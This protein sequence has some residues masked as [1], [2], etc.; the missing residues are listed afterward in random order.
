MIA[1]D[2]ITYEFVKGRPHAPQG[3]DW[4][5][6]VV[7]AWD[8]LKTDGRRGFRRRRG[9]Y[10]R[11][12]ADAVRH[13]GNEPRPGCPS[14]RFGSRPADFADESERLAAEKAL[15]YMGLEAG[16]PLREVPVDTVSSVRA[17]TG[18]SRIFVRLQRFS[19][20][21]RSQTVSGCSSCRARCGW[22][23]GRGR[24]SR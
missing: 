23:A 14:R 4:D 5:A 10:R 7:A 2:E 20:G 16:T 21:A 3:A 17:P 11:F 1:P 19:R 15:A 6:A 22:R 24:G 8:Q 13:L 9:A 12:G 18:V